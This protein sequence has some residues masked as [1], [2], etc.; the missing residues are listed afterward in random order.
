MEKH[1]FKWVNPLFQW[2]FSI[3]MLVYQRVMQI[4]ESSINSGGPPPAFRLL[5]IPFAHE[6]RNW[7]DEGLRLAR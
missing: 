4:A 6:I 3:A 2:S 1:D 5:R 7:E